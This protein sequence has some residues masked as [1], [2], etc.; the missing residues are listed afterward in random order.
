MLGCFE[1][2]NLKE[3]DAQKMNFNFVPCEV[4]YNDHKP[5]EESS[6]MPPVVREPP[7]EEYWIWT[8][9]KHKK[10]VRS[11]DCPG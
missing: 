11:T 3:G 5:S 9:E 1:A 6:S 7:F 2:M 8:E 4:Q 10:P